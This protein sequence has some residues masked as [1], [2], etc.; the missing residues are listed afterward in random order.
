[1]REPLASDRVL[2]GKCSGTE[3]KLDGGG[4][5]RNDIIGIIDQTAVPKA[6]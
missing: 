3:V 2:F 1:L 5:I 4:L 6:A